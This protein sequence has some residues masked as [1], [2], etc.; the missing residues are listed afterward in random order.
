MLT[1]H[2]HNAGSVTIS[3]SPWILQF[4]TKHPDFS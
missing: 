1:Q 2:P 4:F 3:A